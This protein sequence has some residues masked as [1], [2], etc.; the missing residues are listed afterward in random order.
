MNNKLGSLILFMAAG[1]AAGG[2]LAGVVHAQPTYSIDFQGPTAAPGGALGISDGDILT[3]AAPGTVP[4]PAVAI[5][6]A[7]GPGSL[8]LG[9]G[10]MGIQGG[11]EV[12]A[13][14]YGLEPMLQPGP[15]SQHAW[16]FSVDEFALGLLGAPG[17]SVTTEGAR[18]G[19]LMEA[20]ADVFA[21][22]TPAGPV[23]IF[24][25]ANIGIFDG[26]GGTTPFLGPGLNLAEPNPPTIG[27]LPDVG[28]NLDAWDLDTPL[29]VAPVY[30]SLDSA[31]GDP[32]EPFPA[33]TGTALAQGFVGGDVLIS[34]LTGV[35]PALYADSRFL[36]LNG[37]VPTGIP[38]DLDAD[39]LDALVLWDNGNGTYE[40]TTEPYSWLGGTDMLLYSLR[41]NS[42]LLLVSGGTLDALGSGLAITEGDILIPVET[43]P[44][45][46]APGIFIPAENLGLDTVRSGG[47]FVSGLAFPNPRFGLDLWDDEL[48]ALDV[49]QFE[50]P[51]PTSMSLMMLALLGLGACAR[52]RS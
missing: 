51:E 38:N 18:A 26:N 39:D 25:G 20:S 42:A 44:G 14:S 27:G 30:F 52:R 36:G 34:P 3:P 35:A 17:P 23:P 2:M 47:G 13:L 45:V 40:P 31:F 9:L 28:D 29:G 37:G 24:F 50:I 15:L 11:Y 49:Q 48:D 19:M 10:G 5:P 21:S 6:A 12:D 22:L 4:P 33:N 16:T 43:S 32:F 41:R 8:G 1:V 7:G 46:Y